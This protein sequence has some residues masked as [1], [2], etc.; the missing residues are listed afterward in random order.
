MQ[1]ISK[2]NGVYTLPTNKKVTKSF[3][4]NA[5]RLERANGLNYCI[6]EFTNGKMFK[7]TFANLGYELE[8]MENSELLVCGNFDIEV[9][10]HSINFFKK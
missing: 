6:I 7:V 10:L 9:L 2:I 5:L 3:I 1:Q 8:N 4:I